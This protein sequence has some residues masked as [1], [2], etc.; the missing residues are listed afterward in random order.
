MLDGSK[1]RALQGCQKKIAWGKI[2]PE[3]RTKGAK[4]ASKKVTFVNVCI[5]ETPRLAGCYNTFEVSQL[6]GAN[7][8][9]LAR[10]QSAPQYSAWETLNPNLTP[11]LTLT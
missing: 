9:L 4:Q 6:I 11:N 5:M 1:Y 8:K 3:K 2:K 7:T 10:F